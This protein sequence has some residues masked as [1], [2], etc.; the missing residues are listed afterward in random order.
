MDPD[1]EICLAFGRRDIQKGTPKHCFKGQC[2]LGKQATF[3]FCLG[4]LID[5]T[6]LLASITSQA[7]MCHD[8]SEILRHIP[9]HLENTVLTFQKFVEKEPWIL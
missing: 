7:L 3:S 6:R 8:Y 9:L 4:F 5:K 2:A 1:F